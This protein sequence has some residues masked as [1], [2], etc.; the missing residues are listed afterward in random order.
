M[1]A[2]FGRFVIVCPARSGSTMLVHLLRSHPDCVSN[3]EVMAMT[4]SLGGFD[5]AVRAHVHSLGDEESLVRWRRHDPLDFMS[6]VAFYGGGSPWAGFK[7]KSDE[8]VRRRYKSVLADLMAR[9]DLQILHLNRRNLLERY[10]S[11]VMVNK[12]TRVTMAT[13]EEDR[14]EFSAVRINPRNAEKDF[15]L[16][17]KRESMVD[18]WFADSRVLSLEY[19]SLVADPVAE[20]KRICEFLEIEQRLLTTRTIKITPHV[21]GLIANFDEV[22]DYFVGGRFESLFEL[23]PPEPEPAPDPEASPAPV[24][25]VAP[26]PEP[27]PAPAPVTRRE[28]F[29]LPDELFPYGHEGWRAGGARY[30]D[31][32]AA[33]MDIESFRGLRLLAIGRHRQMIQETAN[34]RSGLQ[35]YTALDAHDGLTAYCE[36]RLD[37]ELF[38]FHNVDLLGEF[39]EA[40]P[41]LEIHNAALVLA[42]FVVASAEGLP[43]LMTNVR[44]AV[45]EGSPMLVEVALVEPST[46]G[47]GMGDDTGAARLDVADNMT[48]E[49]LGARVTFWN[50]EC[51]IEVLSRCGWQVNGVFEPRRALDFHLACT[52]VNP[53]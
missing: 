51:L 12:I 9:T 19:E 43:V 5:V 37:G 23:P 8:L 15:L 13:K 53:G 27:T 11:W 25:V 22:R 30:L 34:G 32:L 50:R 42:P 41:S 45:S 29:R 14:P 3:G 47:T 16:A 48:M 4:D 2:G 28:P 31:Y 38:D 17:E 52:A 26:G 7:I 44:N 1:S 18:E 10:V 21:S 39:E 49:L 35:R 40:W 24:V 36:E 33:V 20:S 46:P 6:K